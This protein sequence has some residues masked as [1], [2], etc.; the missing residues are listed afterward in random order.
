MYNNNKLNIVCIKWGT[1]FTSAHVNILYR[2]VKAHMNGVEH[3]FVCFTDNSENL[4]K[5]I[6]SRPLWND[7][8][9]FKLNYRKLKLYSH[10]I[11]ES[12]NYNIIY[13][14][15]DTVITGSLLPFSNLEKNTLWKSISSG[16]RKFVYNTSFVRIVDDEFCSAWELFKE[17]PEKLIHNSKVIDGW[18]G[19]DQAIISHLFGHTSQYVDESDGIISLRDHQEICSKPFLPNWVKM[20]SFYHNVKCGDMSNIH[21]IKKH[22]WLTEHWLSYADENDIK[23]LKSF[24]IAHKNLDSNNKIID[25][26]LTR[27]ERIKMLLEKR[28]KNRRIKDH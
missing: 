10:E 28:N 23:T 18:T 22:P 14:D 24:K 1:K 19:S 13:L 5:G 11:L 26:K 2:A 17:N 16:K 4:D 25:L 9:N 3:N 15:L 8:T 6:D 7:A 21:L 27:R 20:V 12:L